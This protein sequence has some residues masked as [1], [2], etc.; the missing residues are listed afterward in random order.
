MGLTLGR[1]RYYFVMNVP[2][3]LF[4]NVLGK[5]GQPVRQVRQAL[6]TADLSVAK[7][8]AFELEELKRSEWHLLEMGEE[9]LAHEKF[10]AARRMA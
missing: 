3:H 6:R 9:A 4:G 1:G 10:A 8:K 5:T 2:K 7:R